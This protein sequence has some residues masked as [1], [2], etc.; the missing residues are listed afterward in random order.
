VEVPSNLKILRSKDY[1][2][3]LQGVE[4]ELDYDDNIRL[5]NSAMHPDAGL[6]DAGQNP[7]RVHRL[8][9]T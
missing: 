5:V 7:H 1:R 3:K 6:A 2:K 9:S 4:T 8:A